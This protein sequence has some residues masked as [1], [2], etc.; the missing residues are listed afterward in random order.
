MAKIIIS[1]ILYFVCISMFAQ[2]EWN[3][4]E[5]KWSVAT[6]WST[7]VV[8]TSSDSVIINT[9]DA[10]V[11]IENG[12]IKIKALYIGYRSELRIDKY[13]SLLVANGGG[14]AVVV[15]KGK[16]FV[17][18]TLDIVGAKGEGLM[19][20][21]FNGV[22]MPFLSNTG[23]IHIVG[24][25]KVGLKATRADILNNGTL[26]S[27]SNGFGGFQQLFGGKVTNNDTIIIRN[28]LAG[29]GV[30][31]Y[32]E[33]ENNDFVL[34]DNVGNC[35]N[36]SGSIVNNSKIRTAN[37]GRALSIF[38]NGEFHNN[39]LS[40]F[41]SDQNSTGITQLS[42]TL[43]ENEGLISV[44]STS[45]I[46][47]TLEDNSTFRTIADGKLFIDSCDTGIS[48][49]GTVTASF[50]DAQATIKNCNL[51][52]IMQSSFSIFEFVDA[53][54]IFENIDLTVYELFDQSTTYFNA[55]SSLSTSGVLGGDLF[56]VQ[57]DALATMMP[58]SEIALGF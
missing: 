40:T 16:L 6:N 53:A 36:L 49:E 50:V 5:G 47:I 52:G 37:S 23:L 12:T 43:M 46:A 35:I 20:T 24:S 4:G 8:P 44:I 28:N 39:D 51:S 13:R 14:D 45:F 41:E 38:D 29:L 42:E 48:A 18:G 30:G 54:L 25:T 27:E 31:P 21:S 58:G 3:G 15:E 7:G 10:R 34:I 1:F 9:E 17:D 32:T 56:F 26:I 33:F 57:N 2:V 19:L 11:S 22:D 55:T